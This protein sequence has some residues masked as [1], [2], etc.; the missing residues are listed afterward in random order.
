VG[1]MAD[2][3]S[4]YAWAGTI[5]ALSGAAPGSVGGYGVLL[6]PAGSTVTEGT[7]V[8]SGSL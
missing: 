3:G 8:L 7:P 1:R 2:G 4:T 6:V 5:A